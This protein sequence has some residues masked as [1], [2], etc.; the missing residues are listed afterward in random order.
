[1]QPREDLEAA[2]RR[3]ARSVAA[4]GTLTLEHLR[5]AVEAELDRRPTEAQR[6]ALEWLV[7]RERDGLAPPRRGR[8]GMTRRTL[9]A[10]VRKGL[11]SRDWPGAY[12]LTDEGRRLCPEVPCDN[13]KKPIENP[14]PLG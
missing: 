8:A 9:D 4:L 5:D 1:M 12:Y 7:R 11:A 14:K 13:P 2:A 10:L 6:R 3:V